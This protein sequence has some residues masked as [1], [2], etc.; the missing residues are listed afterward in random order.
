MVT[1]TAETGELTENRNSPHAGYYIAQLVGNDLHFFS[2]FTI[3]YV[4]QTRSP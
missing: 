2:I 1:N 3:R 4:T